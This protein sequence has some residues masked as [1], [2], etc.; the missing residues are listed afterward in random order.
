MD[1]ANLYWNEIFKYD[2][3]GE[4]F[5]DFLKETGDISQWGGANQITIFANVENIKIDVHSHGIPCQSYE[6]D[7][8]DKQHNNTI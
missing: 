3:E 7:I 5:I 6:F 2:I 8:N 4:E 1:K